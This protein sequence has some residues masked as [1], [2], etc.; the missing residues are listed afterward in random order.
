LGRC[1]GG[2]VIEGTLA[3]ARRDG[4]FD[5]AE[6]ML[7]DAWGYLMRLP[8]AHRGFLQSGQRSWWPQIVRDPV[9]DCTVDD[10][11]RRMPLG[12]REMALV[13]RVFLDADCLM[14]EV[15]VDIRPLVAVVLAM[16]SRPAR[17]GFR[18]EQVW[19]RMGG[20]ACGVSSD[21][22]RARYDRSVRRVAKVDADRREAA[23]RAEA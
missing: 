1:G 8:D 19:E 5:V 14:M 4:E 2:F 12:R 6:E 17:G 7:L 11:P 9:E 10:A 20:Q 15:A 18:W 22:L 21:G 3:M 23:K 13:D 16:K